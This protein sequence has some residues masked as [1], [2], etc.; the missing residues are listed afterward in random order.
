MK[1][2]KFSPD[3]FCLCSPSAGIE[4][5]GNRVMRPAVF[6]VDTFSAGHGQVT[7]YLD[8]PDGTREEVRTTHSSSS[9]FISVCSVF[10]LFNDKPAVILCFC[11]I[12]D[13]PCPLHD[14]WSVFII[15]LCVC[16]DQL[17]AE[18]NEGKKTFSITYIPQVIGTHKV[19][20]ILFSS[21]ET[22][23]SPANV[24]G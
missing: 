3:C 19:N 15:F 8:H 14:T 16:V 24:S 9:V 4:P 18:P 22:L 23:I 17:K 10:S 7:V 21:S 1:T 13:E 12:L 11:F 5:T 6:T 2:V 20:D